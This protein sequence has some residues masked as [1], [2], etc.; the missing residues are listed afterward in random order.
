MLRIFCGTEDSSP[1]S[2]LKKEKNPATSENEPSGAETDPAIAIPKA[3]DL[4]PCPQPKGVRLGDRSQP[5]FDICLGELATKFN[6]RRVWLHRL[7][8]PGDA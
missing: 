1:K 3:R 8:V 6:C 7:A 5:S 2:N 4:N